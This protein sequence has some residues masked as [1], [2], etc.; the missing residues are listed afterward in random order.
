MYIY[1]YIMPCLLLEELLE[2]VVDGLELLGRE[3][4]GPVRKQTFTHARLKY[5]YTNVTN[6]HTYIS[7]T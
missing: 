2:H 4:A 6:A 7:K 5:K 3:L 1:I